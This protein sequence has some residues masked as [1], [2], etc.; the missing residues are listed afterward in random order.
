MESNHEYSNYTNSLLI[1]KDAA[2]KIFKH[3]NP[4][5][6]RKIYSIFN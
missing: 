2:K 5:I 6:I 4:W 3:K 1:N